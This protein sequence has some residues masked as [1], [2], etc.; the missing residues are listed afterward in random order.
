MER[1]P[2]YWSRG[3]AKSVSRRRALQWAGVGAGS[4]IVGSA[5]ACG[6]DDDSD[7][8][9]TSNGPTAAATGQAEPKRGGKVR[10]ATTYGDPITLDPFKTYSVSLHSTFAPMVYNRVVRWAWGPEVR[11]D[12]TKVTGDLAKSWE[13]PEQTRFTFA[14]NRNVA[15]HSL[16]PVNGRAMTSADVKYTFEYLLDP[17]KKSSTGGKF[18]ALERVETPDDNTVVFVLKEPSAP[19]LHNLAFHFYWI[20]PH[21]VAD[22]DGDFS[23]T[24]V[25]TGPFMWD[26]WER[27]QKITL[28]R[29]PTYFKTGKPY[30]DGVDVMLMDSAAARNALFA[31]QLDLGS[32][33]VENR[34]PFTR[35]FPDATVFKD[36]YSWGGQLFLAT[37]T[38]P[39]LNDP[40]VVKGL[41]RV[42]D[43]QSFIDRVYAGQG[44][45]RG[46]IGWWIDPWGLPEEE[47][48]TL[49]KP[50]LTQAKQLLNAAAFPFDKS[51]EISFS[52]GYG[53]IYST[54]AQ[55]VQRQLSQIGVQTNIKSYEYAEFSARWAKP[56][57]DKNQLVVGPTAGNNEADWLY[58][59]Y[60]PKG[61]YYFN[62]DTDTDLQDRVARQRQIMDT[63]ERSKY[64]RDIQRYLATDHPTTVFLGEQSSMMVAH[65]HLK[66]WWYHST[67]A[68]PS[69]EE[70]W[71]QG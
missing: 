20:V 4:L 69:L 47:S 6:D 35:Q 67:Y 31:R 50:D 63:S 26:Q 2:N 42:V 53:A 9:T 32:L 18:A 40:R 8:P 37:P 61:E 14:L 29:N 56:P 21:E 59:W 1:E 71:I 46:N 3:L 28:K 10:V 38:R 62:G 64:V 15:F 33:S 30:I 41:A 44:T 65:S 25:G 49:Y 22:R 68:W 36:L 19:F 48:R 45:W 39:P 34:D 17:A 12:S 16:P 70:A 27:G 54:L 58:T 60:S 5:M 7:E 55:E 51:L 66:N 11:P 13:I 23:K 43:Q 52:P 57:W 24:V